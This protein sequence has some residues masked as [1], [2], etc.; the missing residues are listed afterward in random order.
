MLLVDFIRENL[1]LT[2]TKNPLDYG[3]TGACTILLNG[4]AVKSS[5]M[6]A[7]QAD[8]CKLITIEGL[9]NSNQLNAL[10]TSFEKF[11]AVQCGY[12]TPAVLLV[13][14]E[15]LSNTA[16]P[17]EE[18]IRMQLDS[19]LCRCTGFQNIVLAAMDVAKSNASANQ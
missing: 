9:S 1:G 11:H 8:N 18:Q 17:T 2:G 5:M 15:L 10:Q 19:V 6:L 3:Q 16:N 14:T 13:L 12:C 4:K 7:V